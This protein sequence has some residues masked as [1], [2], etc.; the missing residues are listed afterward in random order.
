MLDAFIGSR[1][2]V[3]KRREVRMPA[4]STISPVFLT[5]RMV[6]GGAFK[7]Y[8]GECIDAMAGMSLFIDYILTQTDKYAELADDVQCFQL[9]VRISDMLTTRSTLIADELEQAQTEY[10]RRLYAVYP[11][12]CKYKMHDVKHTPSSIRKWKKVLTCLRSSLAGDAC[13]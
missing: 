12:A 8:A 10:C 11:N 3:L 4:G 1:H 2:A 7:R 6:D 13:V 5:S 9:L